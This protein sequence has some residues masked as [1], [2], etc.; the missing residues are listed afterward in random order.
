MTLFRS[1]FVNRPLERLILERCH[2]STSVAD[3]MV[4]MVPTGRHR[5]EHPD[6]ISEIGSLDQA[7]SLE[8]FQGPVDTGDA[9]RCSLASKS[10]VDLVG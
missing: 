2:P 8:C 4:V 3:Q 7:Q 1:E 9:D 5:F 6:A 10:L